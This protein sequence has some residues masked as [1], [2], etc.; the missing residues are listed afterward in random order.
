MLQLRHTHFACCSLYRVQT[1]RQVSCHLSAS[2]LLFVSPAL[3]ANDREIAPPALALHIHSHKRCA[4]LLVKRMKCKILTDTS[5]CSACFMPDDRQTRP[6]RS[7][8]SSSH[9]RCILFQTYEH[10]DLSLFVHICASRH[11]HPSHP[12]PLKKNCTKY[13][14]MLNRMT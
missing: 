2:V 13:V 8:S 9:G 12:L 1:S 3:V 14:F 4:L 11:P 5:D 7:T 6:A 10:V